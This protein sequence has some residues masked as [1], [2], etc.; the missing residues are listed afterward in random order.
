MG[1]ARHDMTDLQVTQPV[2]TLFLD[3]MFRLRATTL[4]AIVIGGRMGYSRSS[5]NA[6]QTVRKIVTSK[7]SEQTNRLMQHDS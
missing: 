4:L 7:N 3:S 6:L 1:S 5:R 2:F